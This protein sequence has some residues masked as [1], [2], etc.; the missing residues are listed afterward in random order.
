MKKIYMKLADGRLF[1]VPAKVVA[2]DRAAHYVKYDK[3]TTY[4][5]EYVHTMDDE[6]ELL[7]WLHSNM[8]WYELKPKLEGKAEV[9]ALKDAEIEETYVC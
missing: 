5:E 9:P 6:M 3:D 4:E 1:S 2:H 8:N 7:D